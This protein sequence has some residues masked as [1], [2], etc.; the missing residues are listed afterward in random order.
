MC[1]HRTTGRL[2]SGSEG[3]LGGELEE[4]DPDGWFAVS[5][6]TASAASAASDVRPFSREGFP[7][8]YIQFVIRTTAMDGASRNQGNF[9]QKN[10][11][12]QELY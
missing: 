6:L 3:R 12:G 10:Q 11:R 2:S 1:V 8:D 7:V 9:S 4:P 5:T